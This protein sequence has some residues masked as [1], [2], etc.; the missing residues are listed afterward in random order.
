MKLNNR[1]E[2]I[3]LS[4][5]TGKPVSYLYAYPE[6]K[7]TP[8]QQK[9]W[10][11]WQKRLHADEPIAY[12]L[13]HTEFYGLKFKVNRH[14]LIPRPETELLVEHSLALVNQY[15]RATIID[16]GTGSGA[17]AIAIAKNAPNKII[18]IDISKRALAVARENALDH[19]ADDRI[20]FVHC[21]LIESEQALV[22]FHTK[23]DC[24]IIANLPYVS[25]RDYAQLPRNV[26]KYEPKLAL[27]ARENGLA[28]YR[29]LLGQMQ[30]IKVIAGFFEIAP[31]QTPA[32]RSMLKKYLPAGKTG[33]IK[34]YSGKNRILTFS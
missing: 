14:T 19:H 9:T 13:G 3:L 10:G 27:Y 6:L 11:K 4:V 15:P 20:E 5:L 31:Q 25:P 28:L 21:S 2:E 34:D 26:K 16:V 22:R 8:R 12:I 7:L 24:I 30:K 33:V 17:I 1:A 29:Q 18:A 23:A 32:L